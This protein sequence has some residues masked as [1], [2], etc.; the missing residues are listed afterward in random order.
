MEEEIFGGVAVFVVVPADLNAENL[1]GG[2]Q[3]AI[4]E[5]EEEET[6]V[7]TATTITDDTRNMTLQ[8][9]HTQ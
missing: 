4:E 1:K 7:K 8:T 2:D 3:A 6:M 5:E 9:S